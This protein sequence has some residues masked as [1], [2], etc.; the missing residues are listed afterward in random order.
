MEIQSSAGWYGR[1]GHMPVDIIP[2]AAPL[3]ERKALQAARMERY[4][5][6]LG[7]VASD[8]AMQRLPLEAAECLPDLESQSGPA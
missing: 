8:V 1:P 3:A 4:G 2:P 5:Q 7:A 6:A